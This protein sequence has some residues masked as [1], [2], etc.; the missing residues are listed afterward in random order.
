MKT[1]F[2]SH[3]V[4]YLLLILSVSLHIKATS[5]DNVNFRKLSVN[6]GLSQNTVWGMMQDANNKMDRHDR[7]A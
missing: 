5:T 4:I 2:T 7:R 1:L 3:K 6:E